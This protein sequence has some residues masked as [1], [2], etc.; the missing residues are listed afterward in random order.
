MP[1]TK[2]QEYVHQIRKLHMKMTNEENIASSEHKEDLEDGEIEDMKTDSLKR[3]TSDDYICQT[4]NVS[5]KK[6]RNKPL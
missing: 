4:D 6:A 2:T 5:N 3:K 1:I